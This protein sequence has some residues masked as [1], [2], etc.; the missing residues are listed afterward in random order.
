MW[1]AGLPVDIEPREKLTAA[2]LKSLEPLVDREPLEDLPSHVRLLNRS[3]WPIDFGSYPEGG[4]TVLQWDGSSLR[5]THNRFA[6]VVDPT[7]RYAEVYRRGDETFIFR[8]VFRALL[9]ARLP[10]EGG[11][12]LHAA[13]VVVDGGAIVFFGVSG[14]GKSTLS[15]TSKFPVLSDE[16]TAVIRDG[17]RYFAR[18]SGHWGTFSLPAIVPGRFPIRALIR[19]QKTATFTMRALTRQDA[20]RCLLQVVLVPAGEMAWQK[21]IANVAE[22]QASVP[23]FEM[24][25]SPATPPWEPLL[26]FLGD[27][28]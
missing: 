1:R 7:R 19:I 2:D 10:F 24:G 28:S 5:L 8:S 23:C 14:A 6:G 26:Q 4:S 22:I 16:L 3:I 25:W 15:A 11:L 27:H 12:P 9:L 17:D 20:I 13:S 21:V 18:A